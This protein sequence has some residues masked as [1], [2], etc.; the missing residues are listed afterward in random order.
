MC[1]SGWLGIG[2]S[3]ADSAIEQK[4]LK[5]EPA[6][7]LPARSVC[8]SVSPVVD[9]VLVMSDVCSVCLYPLSVTLATLNV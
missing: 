3:H 5:T 8:L 2:R 4:R 1:D 6:S 9:R 7:P